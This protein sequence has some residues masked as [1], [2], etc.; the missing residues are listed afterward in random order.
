LIV[1]LQEPA[2]SGPD[3]VIADKLEKERDAKQVTVRTPSVAS[4]LPHKFV[5]HQ[6][7]I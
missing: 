5:L 1:R 3:S 7:L 6:M 2:E 4:G